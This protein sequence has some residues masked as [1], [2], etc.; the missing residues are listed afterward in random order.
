[1]IIDPQTKGAII[2]AVAVALIIALSYY[3][4]ADDKEMPIAQREIPVCK[5]ETEV[6]EDGV[7]K[8]HF[9]RCTNG[10]LYYKGLED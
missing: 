3:F 10:L 7:L 5:Q 6:T 2:G 9:Y 8:G 1:M 4:F